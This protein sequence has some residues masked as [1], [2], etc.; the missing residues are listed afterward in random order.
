MIDMVGSAHGMGVGIRVTP[1]QVVLR[2]KIEIEAMGGMLL[3]ACSHC[4]ICLFQ[5]SFSVPTL[6]SSPYFDDGL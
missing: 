4:S 5:S 2:R 3:L 6:I 1:G